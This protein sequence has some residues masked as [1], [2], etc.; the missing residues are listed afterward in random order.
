MLI[1]KQ[2]DGPARPGWWI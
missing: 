1:H 2:M